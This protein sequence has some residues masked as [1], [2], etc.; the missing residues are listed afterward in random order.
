MEWLR[1]YGYQDQTHKTRDKVKMMMMMNPGD[2]D[3]E[4]NPGNYQYKML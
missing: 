3:T 1:I 2:S 4:N